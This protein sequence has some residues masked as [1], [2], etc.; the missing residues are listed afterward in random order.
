MVTTPTLVYIVSKISDLT[1]T[2][3]TTA[4]LAQC[5]VILTGLIASIVPS[6]YKCKDLIAL[7]LFSHGLQ[8]HHASS[9]L[10]RTAYVL[11][12]QSLGRALLLCELKCW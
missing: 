7:G 4:V 3:V 5:S 11:M 10:E 6:P 2:E 1:T 8:K 9:C 12:T